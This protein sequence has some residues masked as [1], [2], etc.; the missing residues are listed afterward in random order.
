[1]YFWVCRC[2]CGAI[3]VTSRAS[4]NCG[5]ARSCGCYR[6]EAVKRACIIHGMESTAEY[7]I[8]CSMLTRC[9]NPN[10]RH[11]KHYG[12]RGIK[13]C[14]RWQSAF[15]NW[16]NDMPPRPSSLYSLDR[17]D[18]DGHYSCGKCEECIANGWPMNVKW[19][20]RGEQR[21]NTRQ[22][23]I[24]T[25]NGVSMC[26]TDWAARAGLKLQ[27]VYFRLFHLHWS[28]EKT[29][30]TPVRKRSNSI[31]AECLTQAPGATADTSVITPS[32]GSVLAAS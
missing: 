32:S 23:R 25:L 29:F 16:Y 31:H 5:K 10:V 20:T 26:I 7:G 30:T 12:G 2:R 27:T 3:I 13:V 17:I 18:N 9:L 4:L 15:L 19:S 14:A 24:I 11:W 21:R 28:V 22:N 8:W 1:M 6:T